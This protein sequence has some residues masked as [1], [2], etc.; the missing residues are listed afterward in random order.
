MDV[1]IQHRL[2]NQKVVVGASVAHLLSYIDYDRK[3][4]GGAKS[5]Q[6]NERV[7]PHIV[8]WNYEPRFFVRSIHF[9]KYRLITT[10]EKTVIA[11]ELA[12]CHP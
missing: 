4:I 1:G 3:Q 6:Y 2:A 11:L 7:S 10:L 9:P 5:R 12:G 8:R